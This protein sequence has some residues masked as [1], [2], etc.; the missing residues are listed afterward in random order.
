MT[1]LEILTLGIAGWGAILSTVLAV[2]EW[3]RRK[4]HLKVKFDLCS[5]TP[6]DGEESATAHVTITNHGEKPVV[7]DG[8]YFRREKPKGAVMQRTTNGVTFPYQLEPGTK[9][10]VTYAGQDLMNWIA[11]SERPEDRVL[12]AVCHDSLGKK[13]FSNREDFDQLDKLRGEAR[14]LAEAD[15]TPPHFARHDSQRGDGVTRLQESKITS[16]KPES[17]VLFWAISCFDKRREK[18]FPV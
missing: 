4:T 2:G 14:R 7:L 1:L 17:P 5:F 9:L 8:L 6:L 18:P 12:R 11:K 13:Y 3:Q 16:E 15:Q 10:V